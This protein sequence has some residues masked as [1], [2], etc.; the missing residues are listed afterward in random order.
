MRLMTA[1]VV[2]MVA[3]VALVALVAVMVVMAVMAVIV[4]PYVM[5]NASAVRMSP[6]PMLLMRSVPMSSIAPPPE[7]SIEKG[8]R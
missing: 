6:G 8:S 5:G 4:V 2:S 7:A 3:V 1:M